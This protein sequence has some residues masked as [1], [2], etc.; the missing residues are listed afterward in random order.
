MVVAAENRQATPG[1]TIFSLCICEPKPKNQSFYGHTDCYR[2]SCRIACHFVRVRPDEI[3]PSEIRAVANTDAD[4]VAAH[5]GA[6]G[7]A[8]TNNFAN[9]GPDS[10]ASTENGA[11]EH[12]ISAEA[13]ADT[14][15][16]NDIGA[17]GHV[18]ILSGETHSNSGTNPAETNRYTRAENCCHD[19]TNPA[20]QNN[21]NVLAAETTDELRGKA[22]SHTRT[23]SAE[24]YWHASDENGRLNR[25]DAAAKDDNNVRAAETGSDV[26]SE[27][28][29]GCRDAH[30]AP[31]ETNADASAASRRKGLP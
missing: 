27:R 30:A 1:L 8:A 31:A 28:A 17:K 29:K 26:C 20:T 3:Q 15:A 2:N 23:D 6:T 4:T 9:A 14:T 25:T 5:S 21:L 7:S 10:G 12:A 16:K 19:R 22:D 18:D 11:A 24:T 13:V